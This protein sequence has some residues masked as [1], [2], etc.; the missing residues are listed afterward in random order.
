M[1]KIKNYVL[2]FVMYISHAVQPSTSITIQ[3]QFLHATHSTWNQ[4]TNFMVSEIVTLTETKLD[5]VFGHVKLSELRTNIVESIARCKF[6][7][8]YCTLYFSPIDP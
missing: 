8:K 6:Q 4:E 7:K 5:V 3:K 2:K 1:I